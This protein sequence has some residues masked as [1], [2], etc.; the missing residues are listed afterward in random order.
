MTPEPR[1]PLGWTVH[2]EASN[3]LDDDGLA[4][5]FAAL[6]AFDDE[7]GNDNIAA[8]RRDRDRVSVTLS[9]R[10]NEAGNTLEAANRA[11]AILRGAKEAAGL[12]FLRP[13][14][15][16]AMTDDEAARIMTLPKPSQRDL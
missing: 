3:E 16:D 13:F 14:R 4:V 8:Y 12:A 9:I 10:S 15:I 2:V 5:L 1:S 11:I 7:G 6:D